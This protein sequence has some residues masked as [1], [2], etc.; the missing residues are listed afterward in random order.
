LVTLHGDPK[1]IVTRLIPVSK[2]ALFG[3]KK[4]LTGAPVDFADALSEYRHVVAAPVRHTAR[5]QHSWSAHHAQWSPEPKPP[6]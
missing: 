3:F 6:G 1:E 2:S 5:E 4:K